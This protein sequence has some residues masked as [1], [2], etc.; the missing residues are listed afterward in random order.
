MTNIYGYSIVI[1]IISTAHSIWCLI[2]SKAF[3]SQVAE[4]RRNNSDELLVLVDELHN[5][6]VH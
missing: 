4:M 2:Y 5:S 6:E 3:G 1:Y